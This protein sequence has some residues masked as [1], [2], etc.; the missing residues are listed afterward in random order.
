MSLTVI[1]PSARKYRLDRAKQALQFDPLFSVYFRGGASG[2]GDQRRSR[3][4]SDFTTGNVVLIQRK[5]RPVT[6]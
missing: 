3:G 2:I 6:R 1:S 5:S 4:V